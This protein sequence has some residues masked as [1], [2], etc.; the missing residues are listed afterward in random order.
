ME[1]K[2]PSLG[3][4]DLDTEPTAAASTKSAQPQR[5]QA[6]A[7]TSPTKRRPQPVS[8]R[9]ST[10]SP[11]AITWIALFLALSGVA[12]SG[13]LAWQLELEKKDKAQVEQRLADLEGRLDFSSEESNQSV[14]AIR[15]KLK[16]A[17]SEIRKLWGVSNDR[18]KKKLAAHDKSLI[19]L[20]SQ[21]KSVKKNADKAAKISG[22]IAALEIAASAT[23]KQLE[24]MEA[25]QLS[26]EQN[27]RNQLDKLAALDAQL[28]SL[29]G[30]IKRRVSE[31]EEAIKAIDA[32]RATVNRELLELKSR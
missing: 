16:W 21:L 4:F 28:A 27:G 32:Y 26:L 17:D 31:N 5:G 15:A 30:D 22:Q 6:P 13:Y 1:R 23:E 14:E 24:D 9:S 19:S 8:A 2:E 29:S 25:G 3:G 10:K 12:G 11:S 7:K 18:N 20:S